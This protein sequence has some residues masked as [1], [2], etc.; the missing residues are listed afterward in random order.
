[1]EIKILCLK[2]AMAGCIVSFIAFL[3]I[4]LLEKYWPQHASPWG[5]IFYPPQ[6]HP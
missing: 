2:L 3:V 6:R 5:N 1:M 4:L